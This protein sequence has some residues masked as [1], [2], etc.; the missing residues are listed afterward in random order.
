MSLP[1][2]AIFDLSALPR[3][4]FKGRGTLPAMGPKGLAVGDQSNRAYRQDDGILCLVLAASEVFLLG[5]SPSLQDRLAAL[6]RGWSIENNEKTYPLLRQHSHAWLAL[7]GDLSSEILSKLCAVDLR[8]T[9]FDDLSVAQTSVAKINSI[10]LRADCGARLTYHW[11]ADSASIS[12]MLTC[13]Q[14][15]ASEF[16]G[17]MMDAEGW[18]S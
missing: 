11:L 17:K 8:P 12:Y 5:P 6:E 7:Q 1:Q 2:A 3:L 16:G 13:L 10:V 18:L 4:G 15:A 9:R 14:D